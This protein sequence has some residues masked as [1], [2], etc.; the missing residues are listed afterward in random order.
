M[1]QSHHFDAVILGDS[2]AARITGALL[3]RAGCRLLTLRPAQ[4]LPTP[5]WFFSSLLLERILDQLDG[6]AVLTKPQ[7]FQ[8]LADEV[9][10]D[11]HGRNPLP[12]E[13]RR[14]FPTAADE[15]LAT[16]STLAALG[17][18]LATL[19]WEQGGLP[20]SGLPSRWSFAFRCLRKGLTQGRLH[21]P[22]GDRLDEL[23][24]TVAAGFLSGLLPGLALRS[25]EELS[26]AEAALL[27]HG[28]MRPTAASAAGL[29]GLLQRRYQ[30]FHG[31]EDDLARLESL[32]PGR[33]Q[34]SRLHFRGGQQMTA[35]AVVVGGGAAA[36]FLPQPLQT[37]TVAD[38]QQPPQIPLG[39][40]VPPVLADHV[41]L[42]G[43]PPLRLFFS[44]SGDQRRVTVECRQELSAKALKARLEALLPFATFAIPGGTRPAVPDLP[45]GLRQ[46][47]RRAV[48]APGIYHSS[49]AILPGLGS[50]GEIL[51]GLSVAT[52]IQRR[53][54]RKPA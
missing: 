17:D 3:A 23:D 20:L 49:E 48:P 37:F 11:F 29:E 45:P 21:E 22:L 50:N 47:I 18:K 2:L 8:Y 12:E 5:T 46:A 9:R 13:V 32:D 44:G 4:T 54:R 25:A 26:L 35:S 16:T 14:E 27:W 40:K 31:Q 39:D 42:A 51:T 34:P 38:S 36:A 43:A 24:S 53:L 7:P 28:V 10:L 19:L 6:R 52:A 15:I 41:V 1:K 30:Q 33:H